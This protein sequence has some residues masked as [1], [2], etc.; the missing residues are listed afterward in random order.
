[1]LEMFVKN[2]DFNSTNHACSDFAH[3]NVLIPLDTSES[4]IFHIH[5]IYWTK[6]HI[7][8]LKCASTPSRSH[9]QTPC[10]FL[11]KVPCT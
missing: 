1:M 3:L 11:K 7:M 2:I 8:I 6:G 4:N 5:C 10:L 9:M